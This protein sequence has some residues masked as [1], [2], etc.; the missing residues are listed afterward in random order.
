MVAP[1]FI[2]TWCSLGGLNIIGAQILWEAWRHWSLHLEQAWWA[3]SFGCFTHAK[4]HRHLRDKWGSKQ[5]LVCSYELPWT[6][7]TTVY[8]GYDRFNN[9]TV[10]CT[11]HFFV[12][13]ICQI[14]FINKQ[15]IPD[16]RNFGGRSLGPVSFVI[17]YFLE[18][19]R[20]FLLWSATIL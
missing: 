5:R 13:V 11:L 18:G 9:I 2:Y 8:K 17:F 1:P 19:L 10:L 12:F 14:D 4:V 7:A 15:Q 3:Q 6:S 16:R 20:N